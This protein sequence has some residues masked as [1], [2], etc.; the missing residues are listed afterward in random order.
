MHH[1]HLINCLLGGKKKLKIVF[2]LVFKS[3]LNYK[4]KGQDILPNPERPV[5]ELYNTW[6]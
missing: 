2:E 1:T 3:V 5:K 4:V 6:C